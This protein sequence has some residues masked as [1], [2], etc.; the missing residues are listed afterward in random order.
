MAML[1]F[2]EDMKF[3]L[4]QD[5]V[6][7]LICIAKANLMLESLRGQTW[8]GTTLG[9]LSFVMSTFSAFTVDH[10]HLLL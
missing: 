9:M 5:L 10:T 4:Q 2:P 7:C 6:R 1:E 8:E 3:N